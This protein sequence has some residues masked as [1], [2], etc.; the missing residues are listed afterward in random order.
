MQ[1]RRLPGADRHRND[2]RLVIVRQ[3]DRRAAESARCARRQSGT[4][5][6]DRARES[7][8]RLNR[9]LHCAEARCRRN[10]QRRRADR[11]RKPGQQNAHSVGS[12][13][14]RAGAVAQRH[15]DSLQRLCRRKG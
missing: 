15:C 8:L 3:I 10:G 7:S 4:R 5:Q 1:H 9:Q 13:R 2:L 11:K 12:R 6:R 14:H